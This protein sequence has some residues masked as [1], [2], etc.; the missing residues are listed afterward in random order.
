VLAVGVL[1]LDLEAVIAHLPPGESHLEARRSGRPEHLVAVF[2]ARALERPVVEPRDF[3]R[4]AGRR[5][6]TAAEV[7]LPGIER[8]LILPPQRQSELELLILAHALR[9]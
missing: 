4:L 2:V 8:V 5:D 1:R 3:E 9:A 6:E 7:N